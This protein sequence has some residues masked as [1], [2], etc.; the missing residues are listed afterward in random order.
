M[1]SLVIPNV[2]GLVRPSEAPTDRILLQERWKPDTDPDNTGR[3]ELPGGKWRAFEP[4]LACLQRE[5]AEE[6]GLQI[7]ATDLLPRTVT[8]GA[9]R[10]DVLT[11]PM[12]VQMTEGPY[13]SVLVVFPA[14]PTE[15]RLAR[16]RAGQGDA[17]VGPEPLHRPDLCD[18][19]TGV[20]GY[21][22][23]GPDQ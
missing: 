12:V 3:F 4:A 11:P 15:R 19:A 6:T 23:A 16:D 8:L 13:P 9:D 2:Y 21:R 14:S 18:P 1:E 5:V 7:N 17:G 22:F 10:V 20:R